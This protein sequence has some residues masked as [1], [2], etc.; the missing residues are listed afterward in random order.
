MF[1][2]CFGLHNKNKAC[3]FGFK[4]IGGAVFQ[5]EKEDTGVSELS[6]MLWSRLCP[7]LNK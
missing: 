5:V 2:I 4:G 3:S 1:H 6:K 7:M